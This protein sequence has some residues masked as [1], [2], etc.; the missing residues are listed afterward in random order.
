LRFSIDD[1]FFD[2]DGL[3]PNTPFSEPNGVGDAA[4]RPCQ[5]RRVDVAA[6][7]FGDGL[8]GYGTNGEESR[9]GVI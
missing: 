8:G 5:K 9:S 1:R 7:P 4:S 6:A 2:P 3:S